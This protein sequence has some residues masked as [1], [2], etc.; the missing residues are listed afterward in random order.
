MTENQ[1][2]LNKNKTKGL[3]FG[4]RQKLDNTDVFVLQLQ[5]KNIER[6]SKFNYLGTLYLMNSLCGK[7]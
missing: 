3:L 7:N 1:L 5:V 4:T 2:V 6:M